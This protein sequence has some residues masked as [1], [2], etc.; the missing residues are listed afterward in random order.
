[1]EK[2]KATQTIVDDS[3]RE[4]KMHG[5]EGF[6]LAVYLDDFADFENGYICW[7]WHEEVQVTMIIEGAF[8]CQIESEQLHLKEGDIVFTEADGTV[9]CI[10]SLEENGGVTERASCQ[11]TYKSGKVQQHSKK[12]D[13][14][15]TV[16]TYNAQGCT[17]CGDVILGSRIS[18]TTYDK[19]PH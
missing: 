12:S 2:M 17:K 6:P 9:Y 10:D 15:C 19:C 14:S 13:G 4:T 8:L 7:H 3:L 18:T 1:M 5:T 16:T 11:H